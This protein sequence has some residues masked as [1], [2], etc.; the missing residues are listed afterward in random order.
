MDTGLLTIGNS[1]HPGTGFMYL[2]QRHQVTIG[3]NLD[4][5]QIQLKMIYFR[6]DL[7]QI[8]VVRLILTTSTQSD[9]QTEWG[10]LCPLPWSTQTSICVTVHCDNRT[11]TECI[12]VYGLALV[13]EPR[14]QAVFCP[15]ISQL[16]YCTY[17]SDRS[18]WYIRIL[19]W[20]NK[21]SKIQIKWRI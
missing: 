2:A 15:S 14:D 3:P 8:C 1:R 11:F 4:C 18:D 19:S 12:G 20:K 5:S 13:H 16:F 7:S 17:S 10:K 6:S 21:A 9:V